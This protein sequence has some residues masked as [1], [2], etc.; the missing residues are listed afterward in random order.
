MTYNISKQIFHGKLLPHLLLSLRFPFFT[1]S[2]LLF[3]HFRLLV[4]GMNSSFSS[5]MTHPQLVI[6]NLSVGWRFHPTD[7][8]LLVHYLKPKILGDRITDS[9]VKEIN[10]PH[11]NPYEL[12]GQFSSNF[13]NIERYFVSPCEYYENSKLRKRKVRD[14]GFWKSTEDPREITI[15]DT[16]EVIGTK[17]SLVY[18][19]HDATEMIMTEYAYTAQID[20]PIMFFIARK[21][22][23]EV[24]FVITRI[25]NY[26]IYKLKR[27]SKKKKAGSKKLTKLAEADSMGKPKKKTRKGESSICNSASASMSAFENKNLENMSASPAYGQGEKSSHMPSDIFV[28]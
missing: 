12:F 4:K 6:E 15:G 27:N 7:E 26:V 2:S 3:S 16:E 21:Y 20:R 13:S 23:K 22:N 28:F 9:D 18:H 17:R 14:G 11:Y 10:V 8:E 19:N 24:E 5:G 1:S 25:G